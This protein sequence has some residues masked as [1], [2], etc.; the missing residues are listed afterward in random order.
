METTEL[1]VSAVSLS[2]FSEP[3]VA[4]LVAAALEIP[5]SALVMGPAILGIWL[6]A[7][8]RRY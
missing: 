7:T 6:Y 3:G 8:H 5:V 4:G 1:T 2:L